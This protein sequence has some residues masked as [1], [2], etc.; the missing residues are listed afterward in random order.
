MHFS[1]RSWLNV[2]YSY[3]RIHVWRR[4]V[5]PTSLAYVRYRHRGPAPCVM[6]W[7]AVEYTT[8]TSLVWID[9]N[10]YSDGN[11]STYLISYVEWLFSVFQACQ[12]PSFNKITQ[13]HT[14]HIVFRP[15]SKPMVF[16]FFPG[17]HSISFCYLMKTSGHAL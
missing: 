6:I 9:C 13:D 3:G 14:L 7:V 10:L 17:L 1:D 2:Q 8:R 12:V 4:R 15:S 11:I 5:Q 16:D